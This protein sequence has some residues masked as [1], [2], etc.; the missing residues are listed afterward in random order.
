MVDAGLGAGF[1]QELGGQ[2]H[3]VDT[4]PLS[5][6]GKGRCLSELINLY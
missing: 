1:G 6:R 2:R 5:P 4:T 3:H